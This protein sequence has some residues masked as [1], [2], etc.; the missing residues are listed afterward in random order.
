V[1]LVP[2]ASTSAWDNIGWIGGLAAIVLLPLALTGVFLGRRR[3]LELRERAV[4]AAARAGQLESLLVTAGRPG[5][6]A[7][8]LNALK[9]LE[10]LPAGPTAATRAA[11]RMR[12]RSGASSGGLIAPGAAGG[13]AL[14][15]PNYRSYRTSRVPS[16]LLPTGIVVVVLAVGAILLASLLSTGGSKLRR[17]VNTRASRPVV[18]VAVLNGGSGPGAA[19]ELGTQL[20]HHG[21]NVSKEAN[22]G[23][24]PP[25]GLE[26]LYTPGEQAQ[27]DL[28]ARLL[29]AGQAPTVAP[30][31][32]AAEAAAGASAKVIVVLP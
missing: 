28:V 21:V 8:A 17:V 27:A 15:G 26:V 14:P 4:G 23:A 11:E 10:P 12:A 19:G 3:L 16:W 24:A 9:G 32:P 1:K 6:A 18:P 25:V 20:K 5:G 30:A 7:I 31:D 22:L 2:S 29:P 13:R